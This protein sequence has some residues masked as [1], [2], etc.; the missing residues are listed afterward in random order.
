MQNRPVS[1]SDLDS[2]QRCLVLMRHAKAEAWGEND[3]ARRLTDQGRADAA[4]AGQWLADFGFSPDHA[5][6]SSST[7]TRQTWDLVS[8][9]AGWALDPVVEDG[10]F[11]A[12]PDT[13]LD[14][15]RETPPEVS[16]LIAIGH[17]PTIAYLAQ[18][19]DD[20]DGDAEAG[21]AMVGG[22]YPTSAL[23]VFTFGGDWVDLDMASA[24]LRA[25]H[26]ERG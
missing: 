12:S 10:L 6:V 9:Q 19:L 25:F 17:N 26:A 15:L 3:H 20:G 11:T 5:L 4:A 23:T 13:A 18:L 24:S 22:G 8:T 1:S 14:L 2:S 21:A 7:R 16:S